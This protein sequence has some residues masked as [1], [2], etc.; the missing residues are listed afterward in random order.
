MEHKANKKAATKGVAKTATKT[1][2]NAA[3]LGPKVMDPEKLAKEIVQPL[4]DA[5][6]KPA[7]KA[8][9]KADKKAK[10]KATIRANVLEVLRAVK[11][12]AV[13]FG[14]PKSEHAKDDH[15]IWLHAQVGDD[16]L[17]VGYRLSHPYLK[18]SKRTEDRVE[19]VLNQQ[20]EQ[21]VKEAASTKAAA[22]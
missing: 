4:K 16:K 7:A 8:D 22:A 11:K 13:L 12:G 1:K 17:R 5:A 21:A 20:G 2:A 15:P 19:Y 9:A 3:K 14:N 10:A 18:E 6:A